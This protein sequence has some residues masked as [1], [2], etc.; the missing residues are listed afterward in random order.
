MSKLY[1]CL[2]DPEDPS[3]SLSFSAWV[4]THDTN[5]EPL[6]GGVEGAAKLQLM[7]DHL[8]NDDLVLLKSPT[9]IKAC[10]AE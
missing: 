6:P 8:R 5:G 4:T 7:A 2:R 3:Y 10:S 1:C 9:R